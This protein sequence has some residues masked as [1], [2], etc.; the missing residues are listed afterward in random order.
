MY[1]FVQ[2]STSDIWPSIW[3]GY[4]TA[5]VKVKSHKGSY[6]LKIVIFFNKNNLTKGSFKSID[7]AFGLG[8]L[9]RGLFQNLEH[10][11]LFVLYLAVLPL[12]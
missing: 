12:V 8:R 3:S 7:L 1:S 5:G 10:F 4:E 6:L 11:S 9:I 2:S